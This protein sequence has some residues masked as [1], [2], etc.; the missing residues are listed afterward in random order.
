MY[1]IY[2]YPLAIT[3]TQTIDLPLESKI[4]SVGYQGG[5]ELVLW[6]L[7]YPGHRPFPKTFRI[8]GTGHP[9]RDPDSLRY[10]GTVQMKSD[11]MDDGQGNIS[12]GQIYVWHVFEQLY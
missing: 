1:S 3:D 11:P 12:S 9:I 6:A 7:V 10:I 2:K 5:D 4:L 8:I